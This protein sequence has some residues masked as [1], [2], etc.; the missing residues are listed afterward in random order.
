[1]QVQINTS[2]GIDNTEGLDRWATEYLSTALARFNQ[3]ITRVEV[4]M[5]DEN[6]GRKSVAD[7]R[8]MLEAR[9]SGREPLAASHHGHT[10]DEAFRGATQK[11]IHM[12]DHALGKLDRHEHRDRETIRKD[13]QIA[14][15]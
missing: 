3:D 15:K 13:V 7:K 2:N 14:P 6:G 11:L 1:M 10:Q 9:I 12:L 4:Q 8:C 5:S